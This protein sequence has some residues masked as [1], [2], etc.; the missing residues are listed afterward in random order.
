MATSRSLTRHN[1]YTIPPAFPIAGALIWFIGHT[2]SGLHL[3]AKLNKLH[4]YQ[5]DVDHWYQPVALTVGILG[6]PALLI[7]L[8]VTAPDNRRGG[9]G[10]SAGVGQRSA[11][12][13]GGTDAPREPRMS[14]KSRRNARLLGACARALSLP[15][16]RLTLRRVKW[17]KVRPNHWWQ[18]REWR[19]KSL[20]IR[21]PA[22]AVGGHG[23]PAASQSFYGQPDP[24]E[25]QPA[26]GDPKRRLVDALGP[27][28]AG[29]L[30]VTWL[31]ARDQ[32]VISL[33]ILTL[34]DRF[35]A[36]A[37]VM[38]KLAFMLGDSVRLVEADSAVTEDGHIAGVTFAYGETGKDLS[39]E[40]RARTSYYL[41]HKYPSPTGAWTL[42]WDPERHRVRVIP[43]APLPRLAPF[44]MTPVENPLMI[45]IGLGAGGQVM[46][47]NMNLNPHALLA[48]PT[49]TGKTF[50][51]N[52]IIASTSA[53]GWAISLVDPKEL[54]FRGHHGFPGVHRLAT[55]E[56]EMEAAIT[57]FYAEM[58]RRYTALKTF[59]VRE[60][61]LVPF[62]LVVDEVAELIERLNEF[63]TSVEK[64][65]QLV[66]QAIEQGMDETAAAKLK[67]KGTKSP[68]IGN[69]WSI[70]RLGRQARMYLILALQRADVAFI[71][72]EARSNA[73]MR[74]GLGPM[75]PAGQ[76][77]M[78]NTRAVVLRV[79]ER[80]VDP[81]TGQTRVEPVP[82]RATA[83]VVGGEPTSLQSFYVPD[84]AKVITGEANAADVA[85]TKEI[86]GWVT[87]MRQQIGADQKP[88][89]VN[90][91]PRRT[92]APTTLDEIFAASL[93]DLEKHD[94]VMAEQTYTRG[95][96]ELPGSSDEEI[97]GVDTSDW[98]TRPAREIRVGSR[99]A[100]DLYD[101]G[102]HAVTTLVEITEVDD[103]EDDLIA[104]S[105]LDNQGHAGMTTYEPAEAIPVLALGETR[106]A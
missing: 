23:A 7:V 102:G 26:G 18:R 95:G 30:T 70:A 65:E 22:G 82:G 14:A 44:P 61:D 25:A 38:A 69:L 77:M 83:C 16:E 35:P 40:F 75:D 93:V 85:L 45:P 104:F 91:M 96:E 46:T 72:G 10:R 6:I 98:D 84:F 50:S 62:V 3:P 20:K 71:P 19:V 54:S 87:A 81:I 60:S 28:A 33:R 74:I 15:P 79:T 5:L 9:T 68:V 99:V 90:D 43:S 67:V 78:F 66:K 42:T 53:A 76:E 73:R 57:E 1:R 92:D 34:A 32:F 21:Y 27:F 86:W 58:R 56:L 89:W 39:P 105:Y 51:L 37:Q 100:I 41:E 88:I 49:G 80:V 94:E 17:H 31:P 11:G 12:S 106:A 36:V 8:L 24:I 103:E 52:S 29:P 47:W 59:S 13:A 55:T 4:A 97:L 63:H 2:I 64:Q 48:G 101:Q